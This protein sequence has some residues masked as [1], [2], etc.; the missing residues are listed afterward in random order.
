MAVP[1]KSALTRSLQSKVPFSRNPR[2]FGDSRHA[3]A[4]ATR[5]VTS[6]GLAAKPPQFDETPL[7]IPQ[8]KSLIC[9]FTLFQN[10]TILISFFFCEKS[11]NSCTVYRPFFQIPAPTIII[12]IISIIS[13]LQIGRR[14]APLLLVQ[15]QQQQTPSTT[16]ST[17]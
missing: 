17:T 3:L 15:G 4:R 5:N 16:C 14:P 8:G 9:F 11:Q 10:P 7:I 13:R 1:V 2:I 6:S 12:L